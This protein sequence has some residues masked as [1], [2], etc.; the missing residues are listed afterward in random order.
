[1]SLAANALVT[2]AA[3]RT[4]LEMK[5][6]FTTDDALIET[7]IDAISSHADRITG[8]N[9]ISAT[10]TAILLD[11]NGER[12]LQLPNWPVTGT[13]TLLEDTVAITEGVDEDFLLYADEGYIYRYGKPWIEGRK[14]YTL[15]YTAG[16]LIGAVPADLQLAVKKQVAWE[17]KKFQNK[18]LG[19]ET[20]SMGDGSTTFQMDE[21]LP[22]VLETVLRY[23]RW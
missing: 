4:Y 7:I 18:A 9:I 5:A 16:Y 6:G 11:G 8:R 10:Y 22:E 20:R 15:T 13:F 14:L 23:Q 17:Y 21:L 12:E 3:V 19:E 2:L 1:M